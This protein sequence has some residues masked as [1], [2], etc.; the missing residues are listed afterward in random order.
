M[1]SVLIVSMLLSQPTLSSSAEQSFLSRH[2]I[3]LAKTSD[4]WNAWKVDEARMSWWF[5]HGWQIIEG[6]KSGTAAL[7]VPDS[8][9]LK[10]GFNPLDLNVQPSAERHQ[11][12]SVSDHHTLHLISL[13]RCEVLYQR[14][15]VNLAASVIDQSR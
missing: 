14:Y 12:W 5:E 11:Y 4:D 9:F 1:F 3:T 13:T 7:D 8:S 15:L 10:E 6:T 2:T